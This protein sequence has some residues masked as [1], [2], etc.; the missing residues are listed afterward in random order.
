MKSHFSNLF[1][2]IV[3]VDAKKFCHTSVMIQIIIL[4]SLVVK[5]SSF[6]SI[7]LQYLRILLRATLQENYMLY[8]YIIT[9]AKPVIMLSV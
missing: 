3:F 8:K 7:L 9:A 4:I 2:N 6:Y 5:N 1:D